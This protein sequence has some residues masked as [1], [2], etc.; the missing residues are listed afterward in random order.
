MALYEEY[1]TNELT[2]ETVLI[3][4]N[5]PITFETKKR[6]KLEMWEK[7]NFK[8]KSQ[9][10]AEQKT[11]DAKKEITA[12]RNILQS[13]LNI[14]D[15]IEWQSL[16][17]TQEFPA[18]VPK[19]KP[20]WRDFQ[21]ELPNRNPILKLIPYFKKRYNAKESRLRQEYEDSLT[22]YEQEEKKRIILYEDKKAKFIESQKA[23]NASIQ[24]KQDSYEEG[25][26]E[27]VVNYFYLVLERSEYPESLSLNYDLY[28]EPNGKLLLAEVELP[29]PEMVPKVLEYKFIA[30]KGE[31]IEKE[32]KPK[33]FEEFYN[34][35]LLQIILRTLHEIFES[36]YKQQ[37]DI[38]VLN[39]F[40]NGIDTK[41]GKEFKNCVAS[42]QV[43][44][45]EFLEINLGFIE[46]KSC[47]RHLKGV[48]A[49]S[50]LQLS[51]VK[52]VMV[53]N[54]EDK[55]IVQADN[56]IESL[57]DKS[58]LAT[59]NW[60]EFEVLI[61]DL[62]QKEFAREGCKVEVTRA[63]RDAGVDAIAF[64]DDPIRGGKYIIQAKRYNNLVPLS[65]VRDLYGTVHNE[66]AVKGI[67]I[68]TSYFGKDSLE[69]VKNKP[70]KLINGEELLFM[71][72]KHGYDFKIE[73]I[74]K[75]SS[76]SKARS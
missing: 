32:M 69:F 25:K 46:P 36:D 37:V 63:S 16:R 66:G 51:P 13:T 54:K 44:R 64:D 40:V 55:R 10:E 67:L 35:V 73:L 15:Q 49:G 42:L 1:L 56:I 28:Y 74:K 68:T 17:Q 31:L 27:G 52:P 47:F 33:N 65:A 57:V 58:N 6:Q 34:N 45:S 60:Q 76:K 12:Y 62:I 53:L 8:V 48:S 50:L 2:S 4:S 11:D 5:D 9:Q 21:N 29:K 61:R 22:L 70:L 20:R 38:A 30:A 18:Y 26:T 72:N 3:K 14:N 24:T 7:K 43:T 41:T 75:A 39:G 19:R 59:M 71:F 23:F